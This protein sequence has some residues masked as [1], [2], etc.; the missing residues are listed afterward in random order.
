VRKRYNLERRLKGK[1]IER[2]GEMVSRHLE[3]NCLHISDP[4][5]INKLHSLFEM[6]EKSKPPES[7]YRKSEVEVIEFLTKKF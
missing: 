1:L 4:V 6:N 2:G 5:A 7:R 3:Q